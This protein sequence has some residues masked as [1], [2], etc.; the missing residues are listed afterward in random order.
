MLTR[1]SMLAR[2]ERHR[3]QVIATALGEKQMPIVDV[4]PDRRGQI[5]IAGRH[6][7]IAA[8]LAEM[9]GVTVRTLSRWSAAGIGPPK[10]KIGKLVLFDV[11]KIPE[12]LS[13]HEIA[14]HNCNS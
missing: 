5:E 7:V 8:R 13:T 6:Y 4:Y 2:I 12:W 11:A 1:G 10:I 3:N 9:L 14:Q